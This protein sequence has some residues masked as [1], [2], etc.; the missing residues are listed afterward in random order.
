MDSGMEGSSGGIGNEPP[1]DNPDTGAG[2]GDTG[3]E[4]EF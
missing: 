2:G 1:T 3:S 4:F